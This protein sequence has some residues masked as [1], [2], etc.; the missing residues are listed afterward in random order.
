MLQLR[1]NGK[2]M[3]SQMINHRI[4]D[5]RRVEHPEARSGGGVAQLPMFGT[6]KGI[7]VEAAT[8]N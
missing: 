8:A 1:P 6:D 3:T 4:C 2:L 5:H 7:P